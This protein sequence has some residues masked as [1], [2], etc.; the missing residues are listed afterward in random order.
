MVA[1]VH[2]LDFIK[3]NLGKASKKR[4]AIIKPRE[5]KRGN[6]SSGNFNRKLL[7]D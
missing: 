7:S 2:S 6:E 4:T 3:E 5:N 1:V